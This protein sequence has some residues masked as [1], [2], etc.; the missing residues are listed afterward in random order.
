MS[1]RKKRG[2]SSS[3]DDSPHYESYVSSQSEAISSYAI[4]SHDID[5]EDADVEFDP[6]AYT[7]PVKRWVEDSYQK[8]R[9]VYAYE[10]EEDSPT[11]QFWTNIQYDAFYGHLVKKL[12]FAHKSIDWNY[13]EKFASTHPLMAKFQHIGL[14]KFTRLTCDWHDTAI[15]QFYAIVE[16]D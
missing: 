8:V 15:R 13:L 6:Q 2:A 14:H 5:M 11:P 16:T 9:T 1:K 10:K 12:V 4:G 3:G 7:G